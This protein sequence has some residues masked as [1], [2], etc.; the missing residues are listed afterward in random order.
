[1]CGCVY[2]ERCGYHVERAKQ[3]AED[4]IAVLAEICRIWL[5][6]AGK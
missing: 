1:M 5:A 2:G 4:F 3:E 6:E